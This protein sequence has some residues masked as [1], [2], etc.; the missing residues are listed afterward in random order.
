MKVFV[1]GASGH[2][3]S[4]LVPELLKAGHAVVGLARS[5]PGAAALEAAGALVWKGDLS[6]LDGLA[7]AASE[8]DGVVHLAYRHDLSLSGRPEG[9]AEAAQVDLEVT[10]ALGRALEGSGKPLVTTTGTALFALR[11]VHHRVTEADALDQGHRVDSENYTV[12]L[13]SRGVRAAVVRLAPT[14]HSSL[15]RRGFV[16]MLV[17]LARRQ[18]FAAYIGDGANVWNAVHTLDAARLY[19]LVLEGAQ[20]GT[21]WHAVAEEA[22]TF[23]SIAQ[24]IGDG[25]GLPTRSLAAEQA[26]EYFGGFA[27]FARLHC[28]ASSSQ[29]QAALGWRPHQP[30]L[31]DDLTE[32]HY[33]RLP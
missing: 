3:G 33:F 30:S 2:I 7:Q 17:A 24:A 27:A 12:G 14:V 8:A 10:Q 6:D 1:T 20:A 18:G 29:T 9:F 11:G 31:I 28:W 15:D 4:A 32:G 16:P 26:S 25:L 13:A 22:V 19:R 5:D 23:R 21:R